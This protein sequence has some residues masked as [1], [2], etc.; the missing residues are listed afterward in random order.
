MKI[1]T[2]KCWKRVNKTQNEDEEKSL[3]ENNH[4]LNYFTVKTAGSY[5]KAVILIFFV[6]SSFLS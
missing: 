2:L 5:P 4:A 3:L 6:I 1:K